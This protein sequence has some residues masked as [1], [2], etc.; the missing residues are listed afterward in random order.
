MPEDK[1]FVGRPSIVGIFNR[2]IMRISRVV[3]ILIL[4][5]GLLFLDR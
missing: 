4:L 2:W 5:E 1:D 3:G